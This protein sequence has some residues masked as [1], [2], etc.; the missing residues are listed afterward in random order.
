MNPDCCAPGGSVAF[1]LFIQD[2]C[3]SGSYRRLSWNG[4]NNVDVIANTGTGVISDISV[5]S[6][7]EIYGAGRSYTLYR[8]DG[9]MTIDKTGYVWTQ[10]GFI[11]EAA[12]GYVRKRPYKEYRFLECAYVFMKC[13]AGLHHK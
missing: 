13:R 7:T 10:D 5:Y 6:S 1:D 2:N 11:F 3:G 8:A 9:E 4:T 12:C